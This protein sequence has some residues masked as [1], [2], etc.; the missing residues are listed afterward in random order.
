MRHYLFI[1][2]AILCI[3]GVANAATSFTYDDGGL[4]FADLDVK[5]S[6]YMTAVYGSSVTV[7]GVF[8]AKDTDF[9]PT[10]FIST[11]TNP[12]GDFTISFD[13]KPIYSASFDWY[14]FE[15][16]EG[17]D[18]QCIAYD[19]Y[20]N[21]V[22][23]ATYDAGTDPG[24]SSGPMLYGTGVTT[25]YFSN[26]SFHDIGIDKLVVGSG[27]GGS[28]IPGPGALILGSMGAGLVGWLRRRRSL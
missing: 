6:Q 28:G 18:F 2:I 12:G 25:L 4:G 16:T 17:A 19:E 14:V 9:N 11:F 21:V 5:V 27:G 8:V 22:D 3:A 26:S 13:S 7:D 20:G 10:Y 23:M 24:G 1:S 15:V